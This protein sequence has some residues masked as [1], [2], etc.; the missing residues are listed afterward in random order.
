MNTMAT[1]RVG[2][3]C[4]SHHQSAIFVYF[5]LLQKCFK[6][7]KPK[8][9]HFF[10]QLI[11]PRPFF[12]PVFFNPSKRV[13]SQIPMHVWF[14]SHILEFRK[15]SERKIVCGQGRLGNVLASVFLQSSRLTFLIACWTSTWIHKKAP[16]ASQKPTSSSPC[17]PSPWLSASLPSWKA[18]TTPPITEVLKLKSLGLSFP[19]PSN[20]NLA[21]EADCLSLYPGS[22]N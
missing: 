15:D 4:Q 14:M 1:T 3:I 16:Q 22:L 2:D 9:D 17:L 21:F 5:F 19:H 12:F 10:Q 7:Y 18:N 13:M 11:C 6:T 8:F 20:L